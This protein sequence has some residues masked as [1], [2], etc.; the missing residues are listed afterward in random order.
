MKRHFRY[1]LDKFIS[2]L[3]MRYIT[4]GVIGYGFNFVATYILTELV[5]IH[6][7]ISYIIAIT[8]NTLFNFFIAVKFI[9]KVR[10]RYYRRFAKYAISM[11]IFY[12]SNIFLVALIVEKFNIHYLISI[13][14]VT[15]FLV[16]VKFLIYEKYIFN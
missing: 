8:V 7:L 1:F 15:A 16:M 6:Y 11:I 14:V 4:G 13:I 2:R 10:D 12:I 5:G 9:F 3:F